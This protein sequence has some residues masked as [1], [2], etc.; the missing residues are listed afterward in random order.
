MRNIFVDC[1][2][3]DGCSIR[4]FN[5]VFNNAG[6]YE[7]Y[8]FEPNP[9]FKKHYLNLDTT[10]MPYAVHNYTGVCN[11]YIQTSSVSAGS[12]VEKRKTNLSKWKQIEVECVRL[13]DFIKNNFEFSDNIILKLDI[14]GLE[15]DVLED[16]INTNVIDFIKELYV[17]FHYHSLNITNIKKRHFS[18]LDK[19]SH[20]NVQVKEW[21]ALHYRVCK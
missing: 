5:D 21:D 3:H 12:T 16:L 20:L 10:L 13:S 19:L 9:K 1:G 6:K 11:F 17:E 4:M 18:L 8:S 14:E 7:K 2:G 15:Y